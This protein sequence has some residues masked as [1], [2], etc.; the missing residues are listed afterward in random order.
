MSTLPHGYQHPRKPTDR[1]N[2]AKPEHG[3]PEDHRRESRRRKNHTTADKTTV[4]PPLRIPTR[5]RK[6]RKNTRRLHH[7]H[8]HTQLHGKNHERPNEQLTPEKKNQRFE[9]QKNH[10]LSTQTQGLDFQHTS[11]WFIV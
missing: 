1:Q 7:L 11:V 3:N 4:H 10:G 5:T 2:K 8:R 9:P 6:Q